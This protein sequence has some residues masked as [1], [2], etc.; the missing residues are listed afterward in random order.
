MLFQV[1][2]LDF[3]K[4]HLKRK[5]LRTSESSGNLHSSTTDPDI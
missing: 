1:V 4:V 2:T 5:S 3:L